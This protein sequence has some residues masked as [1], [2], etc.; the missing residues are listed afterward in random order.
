MLAPFAE[1]GVDVLLDLLADEQDRQRRA[2][3]LGALRRIGPHHPGP[4]LSRLRDGRWFVVRNAV[5]ILGSGRNPAVLPRLKEVA[6]HPSAEVRREVPEAIANA[7]GAAG[8]PPLVELAVD[9]PPDVRRPA[10]T[11]LGTL[12][13]R[14][15]ADGLAEV[16]LRAGDRA[17]RVQAID[18]LG[19]RTE[20]RDVLQALVSGADGS[21]LPWRLR[22]HARRVLGR[23]EGRRG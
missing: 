18:E 9:G 5:S 6:T 16:A 20:D 22:R 12:V 23:G 2:L 8:V 11:S 10:V 21:R 17:L 1:H 3:L 4:V 14:E 19:G 13:G 7:G 15:A